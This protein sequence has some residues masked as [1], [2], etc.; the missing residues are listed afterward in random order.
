MKKII[1]FILIFSFITNI[2]FSQQL[3]QKNLEDLYLGSWS[4]ELNDVLSGKKEHSI[5]IIEKGKTGIVLT[6]KNGEND[7]YSKQT[8]GY[9]DN[10]LLFILIK[11]L[12]SSII[13][14]QPILLPIAI[15]KDGDLI[16]IDTIYKKQK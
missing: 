14:S 11:N 2:T 1:F 16:L 15:N 9:F 10:G 5:L 6:V 3:T 12:G 7:K 8:V 13:F 4:A